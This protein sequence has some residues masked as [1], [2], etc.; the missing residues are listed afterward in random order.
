MASQFATTRSVPTKTGQVGEFGADDTG[1]RATV[2]DVDERV[3]RFAGAG[4][5]RDAEARGAA[6]DAAGG[7]EREVDVGEQLV[8]LALRLEV[9]AGVLA[10]AVDESR[11]GAS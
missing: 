11:A 2:E 10:R 8:A 5:Q 7:R 4:V 3:R 1:G 6:G 9:D